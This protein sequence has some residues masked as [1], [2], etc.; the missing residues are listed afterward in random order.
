MSVDNST[1][2]RQTSQDI[3][4]G[5]KKEQGAFADIACTALSRPSIKGAEPYRASKDT[6]GR[7]F[8]KQAI[9]TD[10]IPVNFS[11]S[12][13]NW[14]MGV[15]NHMFTLDEAEVVDLEQYMDPLT[16]YL[17]TI[18]DSV[19]VAIDNDLSALLV[20]GSFN[21]SHA[22]ANG[23]WS[24]SSSTPVLDMQEA[25]R[26][27][28][29]EAD[30]C[31]LGLTSAYELARHPEF[32]EAVSNYS[33][34]GAISFGA[35][36]NGVAEVLNIPAANVHIFGTYYDSANAGQ[37]LSIAYSAGDLC[38]IGVKRGLI[39][40]EQPNSGL[41]DVQRAHGKVEVSYRRVLDLQRVDTN[42]GTYITGL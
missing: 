6:L 28:C 39:K 36:R 4:D 42:L 8:G 12:S 13:L 22:A 35:M 1:L 23:N 14:D 20:N 9:G 7:D 19:E 31:I 16:A 10:P 17:R 29:P 32:K 24:A 40:T 18:K 41:V 38:W 25:K 27:D 2:L 30:M 15:Y 34:G 5:L 21:A 11:M 3:I 37:A 33:G 26:T